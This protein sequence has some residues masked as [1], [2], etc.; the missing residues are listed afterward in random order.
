MPIR[1]RRLRQWQHALRTL[2]ESE[3]IGCKADHSRRIDGFATNRADVDE[4]RAESPP[5][6]S[7][8]FF[9][10]RYNAA[11]SKPFQFTKRTIP[12][13]LGWLALSVVAGGG[14]RVGA[15]LQPNSSG[16]RLRSHLQQFLGSD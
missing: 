16:L 3:P 11:M 4:G 10:R 9:M 5:P 12:F 14:W 6:S 8:G 2:P 1:T 7:A 15:K 13:A